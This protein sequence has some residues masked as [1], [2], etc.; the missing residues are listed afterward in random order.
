M[1][2]PV[3]QWTSPDRVRPS[4]VQSSPSNF[5]TR[6]GPIPNFSGPGLNW[7]GLI[8]TIPLGPNRPEDFLP[9]EAES[10]FSPGAGSFDS[11]SEAVSTSPSRL[12]SPIH[13]HGTVSGSGANQYW[14]CCYSSMKYMSGGTT[15]L[16][17]HL[18]RYHSTKITLGVPSSPIISVKFDKQQFS[19]KI[20]D[21]ILLLWIIYGNIPFRVTSKFHFTCFSRVALFGLVQTKPVQSQTASLGPG[22]VRPSSWTGPD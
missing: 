12:T 15:K 18:K 2:P 21:E 4:P 11:N 20:A 14:K 1:I 17:R 10:K 8:W 7:P 16:A 13:T 19:Q 3:Q 9:S 6:I 22:P 5:W